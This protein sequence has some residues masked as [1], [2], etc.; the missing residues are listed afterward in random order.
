M[1][2]PFIKRNA[3]SLVVRMIV[4]QQPKLFGAECLS[5]QYVPNSLRKPY[6]SGTRVNHGTV[7]D[8]PIAPFPDWPAHSRGR[9]IASSSEGRHSDHGR[10]SHRN[11]H[12]LANISLN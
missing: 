4:S 3:L 7:A 5:V 10:D 6:G 2:S 1:N 8:P 9:T 12:R 11:Q